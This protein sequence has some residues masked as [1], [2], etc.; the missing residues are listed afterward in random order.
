MAA[1]SLDV[2]SHCSAGAKRVKGIRILGR[3]E[4]H[5]GLGEVGLAA[6][7]IAAVAGAAV[8]STAR[9][10]HNGSANAQLVSCRQQ[11][12][13]SGREGELGAGEHGKGV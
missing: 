8:A 6:V 10:E 11:M 12:S 1:I 5:D 9:D 7:E 2:A 3:Q 13:R 4:I